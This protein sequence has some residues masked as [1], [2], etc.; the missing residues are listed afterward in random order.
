MR[1]TSLY[2]AHNVLTISKMTFWCCLEFCPE[3]S[4]RRWGFSNL[5]LVHNNSHFGRNGTIRRKRERGG[6][7]NAP[8][9]RGHAPRAPFARTETHF[10]RT[11]GRLLPDE[12]ERTK[13]LWRKMDSLAG[14][15]DE[16]RRS[17]GREGWR[18]TEA[19][20]LPRRALTLGA[21]PAR[22]THA[23]LRGRVRVAR[24]VR[25]RA[26]DGGC[27]CTI[28]I[29]LQRPNFLNSRP[30]RSILCAKRQGTLLRSISARS[31]YIVS[32]LRLLAFRRVTFLEKILALLVWQI[33]LFNPKAR[34]LIWLLYNKRI[35]WD[36]IFL[37]PFA[38]ISRVVE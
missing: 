19:R 24:E 21:P 29:P 20:R 2:S 28:I 37:T 27:T 13:A 26:Q 18:S 25:A 23:C 11:F 6:G 22:R 10:E 31:A 15:K 14:E 3:V 9:T 36:Y 7:C 38:F 12:E 30:F 35:F 5:A 1:I 34:S 17:V 16:R 4:V 8:S 32:Q 33:S